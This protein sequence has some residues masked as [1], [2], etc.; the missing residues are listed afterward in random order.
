MSASTIVNAVVLVFPAAMIYAG[1]RDVVS[2]EVPNWVSAFVVAA[3]CA[4]ATIAG[5]A[6]TAV[7]WHLAAGAA[8]LM[9]GW[10]EF[11]SHA[12]IAAA[13]KYPRRRSDSLRPAV[14]KTPDRAKSE[15]TATLRPRALPKLRPE[16][17]E[18]PY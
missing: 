3:F 2:Y 12:P 10:A 18:T 9:A 13:S 11:Q 1:W 4:G 5:L 8:V 7:A 14:L 17:F 6:M 16:Q 15:A